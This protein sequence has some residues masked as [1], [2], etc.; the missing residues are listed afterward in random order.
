MKET[1]VI[2]NIYS[3][4]FLKFDCE[5]RCDFAKSRGLYKMLGQFCYSNEHPSEDDI[6]QQFGADMYGRKWLYTGETE[7]GTDK[8]DGIGICVWSDGGI[9]EGYYK[10]GKKHG[11]GRVSF[12]KSKYRKLLKYLISKLPILYIL[13]TL[14]ELRQK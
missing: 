11:K 4:F 14:K 2:R 6:H 7:K 8:A 3:V 9:Y 10:D 1:Q 5:F 12:A 13:I